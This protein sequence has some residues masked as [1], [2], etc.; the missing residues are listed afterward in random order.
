MAWQVE[1]S[2]SI[3]EKPEAI[4]AGSL[5]DGYEGEYYYTP[6]M[7]DGKDFFCVWIVWD[8][9][10]KKSSGEPDPERALDITREFVH[11]LRQC[12]PDNALRVVFST[13]KGF[14]VYLDSR[15]IEL[16]PSP[17]LRQW[18]RLLCKRLLPECDETLYHARHRIALPG[19]MHR[20]TGLFYT[21]IPLDE[22]N[23]W[24]I[25]QMRVYAHTQREFEPRAQE[26]SRSNVLC[27]IFLEEKKN[28]VSMSR[29][30]VKT[31]NEKPHE[32]WNGIE[33]GNGRNNSMFKMAN[34]YRRLG[35]ALEEVFV[36]VRDVNT[37]NRPNLKPSEIYTIVSSA[38]NKR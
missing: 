33:D 15:T 13:S 34:D 12:V 14:H 24:N 2:R 6:F 21:P 1:I 26:M 29:S 31:I 4:D 19:S 7:T 11:K 28:L 17:Y 8:V 32:F 20:T 35:L 9:D 25:S 38:F 10:C 30:D 23:E 36:L 16:Q 37:R 3:L 27:S 22:L 18:V 5:P